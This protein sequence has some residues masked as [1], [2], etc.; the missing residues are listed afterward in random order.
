[1]EYLPKFEVAYKGHSNTETAELLLSAHM[2]L[3]EDKSAGTLPLIHCGTLS[4][5][6][7]ASFSC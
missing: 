3:V 7:I 6:E 4:I 1:V 2:P 5:V